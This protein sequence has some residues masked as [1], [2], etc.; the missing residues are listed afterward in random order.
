MHELGVI[1]EVV[2]TVETFVR[3]NNLTNVQS[4]TLQVGELSSMV[5]K[6]IEEL[7]PI[8]VENTILKNAELVIEILPGLGQCNDCKYHFN[9]VKHNNICPTC[10]SKNWSVLTGTEFLIKEVKAY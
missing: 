5:P 9:L 8:A 6:Y 1:I 10:N 3:D 2:K 7:Y 4:L